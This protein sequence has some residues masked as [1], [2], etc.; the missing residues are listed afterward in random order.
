MLRRDFLS[1]L[2]AAAAAPALLNLA[3]PAEAAAPGGKAPFHVWYNNDT[4]NMSLDTP[5]HKEGGPLTDKV[6]EGTIDEVA[7]GVDAYAFCA[8]L[9]HIP[10]WKSKVY[11]DHYPWWTKKTGL[12]PDIFGQYLL[13]GG[14]MVRTV[15][16]RCRHHG[17]APIVSM[18]MNDVH[19]QEYAGKKV[20]MSAWVSRFNEEHPELLLYPDHAK[21]WPTGYCNLRGQNW[22]KPPVRQRKL[23][24]LTE[25]CEN[26]DLAGVELDWL[27]DEH[28]FPQGFPAKE[29][30]TIMAGFLQ[31]VRQLLD[32]TARSGRR[33]YLGVRVPLRVYEHAG[34]GFDVA[35]AVAAG[36]DV[37]NC[38]GWYNSNPITDIAAIRR[39]APGATILHE[40]THT[41]GMLKADPDPSGYHTDTFPRTADEMFYTAANLAYARGADGISLFNFVYY[42]MGFGKQSWLVREP[43]FHVLPRLRDRAWLARQPQFYWLA[44]SGYGN[45][46]QR[47][48]AA[49]RSLDYRFDVAL[50]KVPLAPNARLRVVCEQSLA[51]AR[52]A[53]SMNG[54]RLE[55]TADVAPPF[56]YAYDRLLGAKEK[57]WAWLCP[58]GLL[59]DGWNTVRIT[60]EKAAAK[61]I[62]PE[63]LDLAVAC[64]EGPKPV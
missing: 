43:P 18:R 23:D 29:A 49:G 45:Q 63:W 50:P 20:P 7:K 14:D 52:L 1:T 48:I 30:Q 10:V 17:M 37:L 32:R 42:R 47:P 54:H 58:S 21:K 62:T 27:R 36:V 31:Q 56:A 41:A 57:R 22:A 25:L 35:R 3:R 61:T 4:T 11:P 24:F 38:S 19:Q 51:G 13:D 39:A 44:N 2:A 15:V 46:V 64:A 8:G 28:I 40:L 33:R 59:H 9:G 12:R 55:S 53:A 6:I 5:F 60:V 26:Y 16:A 34:F